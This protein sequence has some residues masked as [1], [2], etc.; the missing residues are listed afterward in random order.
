[1][2]PSP[3]A[4]PL[5]IA[6]LTVVY[7]NGLRAL[8]SVC[9]RL[10]AD[11]RA[12]VVGRSG[13]GKTSLVR[14]VLGLLP[15]G[16]RT[17]GTIRVAGRDVLG[18]PERE[19]RALR[20]KVI[21]YVP[22]DPFAACDP[23]RTV[24]HHID[25]TWRAHRERPPAGAATAALTATGID[26]AGARLRQ[27]PHQWSGGML[28]RATLVAATAHTPTL[29]LADEPTSALDA[30][31]ADEV[32]D[33]ITAACGALLLISHDLS[34]VARHADT[35]VV[36]DSGR[37]VEHGAAAQVLTRPDSDRTRHLLAAATVPARAHRPNRGAP[38]AEASDVSRRYRLPGGTVT[39][40][41]GA[42][43]TVRTGEIVGVTGPSGSGKS[44][45]ARIVAGMEHPDTGTVRLD[46]RD[47]SAPGPR[48][49]GLV[50]PVFQD[51]VSSLD[52][53]WPLWRTL[54]EPGR[55]RGE[56]P[57]RARAQAL[58]ADALDRVGLGD[59]DP[60]R[61]PGTLSVGQAQ[62]VAIARALAARPRLLVADEPTASLDVTTATEITTLLRTVADA[63]TA[64]LVV[65]HDVPRLHSYADRVLVMSRGRLDDTGY[66]AGP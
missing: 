53:R 23:L 51:P 30:H 21:G 64:V 14:A 56:R 44:T 1:M 2:S 9:L 49:P 36:L 7:P 5:E 22:Q 40:V 48:R 18:L 27:H 38:V 17:S 12:A 24:G 58:A 63:G 3:Q 50:M 55:A 31:L 8:D 29:T 57:S 65:S 11:E 43:L 60:R 25:E 46:G 41:D 19:L 47:T 33:A 32:L 52:H 13:S 54:T 59:I 34:L 66:G 16:T 4:P 26:D 28:Q 42:T 20:G 10:D 39:A 62:R 15:P 35:L 45:L 37:V 6:D 61:L